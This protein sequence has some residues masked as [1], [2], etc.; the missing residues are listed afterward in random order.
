MSGRRHSGYTRRLA[1]RAVGGQEV[2]IDLR[3]HRYFCDNDECERRTFAEQIDGL[4]IR[5]G[6]RSVPL[7]DL[8]QQVALALGG[9]AGA[10]LAGHLA[11]AVSATTL[12]RLVRGLPLPEVPEVKV[13]GVDE[14]AT[15]KGHVYATILIDMAT[16]RPIDVLPDRTS[17]T[18]AAWLTAHPGVEIIGRDR[19]SS[20]S[21]GAQSAIPGV[22]E[23]ADRWHL[24]DNLINAARL[25][26]LP[27][28]A[29]EGLPRFGRPLSGM[30]AS[31]TS[32]LHRH[33]GHALE[34]ADR[35]RA[36]CTVSFV[37][38]N[39][40]A[41]TVLTDSRGRPQITGFS[42]SGVGCPDEDLATLYVHHATDGHWG[43][44]WGAYQEITGRAVDLCHVAWHA[45]RYIHWAH[46]GSTDPATRAA[47]AG[48]VREILAF[49]TDGEPLLERA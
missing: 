5:Y 49:L 43:E 30:L 28:A 41:S 29:L 25:H 9:R 17:Q 47:A 10:R 32:P 2:G 8:L 14:F 22:Q 18:F 11:A 27:R 34:R 36:D 46:H 31:G 20:Y 45:A 44:L 19:A 37:H 38:G 42:R 6:R 4:T 21:L 26:S 48:T 12:L 7:R 24:F 40:H 16:H 1:N 15:R 33:L 3:V 39:L 13:L 23:V 35:N